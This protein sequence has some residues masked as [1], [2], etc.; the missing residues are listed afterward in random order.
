MGLQSLNTIKN[1]FK[2][3]FI[4]T[5]AQ[6]WDMFDSFR[7]KS[8][9][10]AATDVDGLDTLLAAKASNA[11]FQAHTTAENAH[12]GLFG[13]LRTWVESQIEGVVVDS[14]NLGA[15]TPLSTIPDTINVHGFAV[16]EG[17][18]ANCGG[19]V[20]PATS[21]AFISR[22]AGVWKITVTELDLG[23]YEK[24]ID[25]NKKLSRKA[26]TIVGKNKY[27]KNT[28]YLNHFMGE[29]GTIYAGDGFSISDFIEVNPLT[30]Y[31]PS[32]MLRF[33][34]YF[35][36]NKNVIVGGGSFVNSFTTSVDTKYV[37]V[38]LSL[39]AQILTM[40]LEEGN[41]VTAYENYKYI[42]KNE[43]NIPIVLEKETVAP[44]QTKGILIPSKNL[45]NPETSTFNSFISWLDGNIQGGYPDG[46]AS[47]FI[48]VIPGNIYSCNSNQ[49]FK[50]FYAAN[51]VFVSGSQFGTFPV[52]IPAGCYYIKITVGSGQLNT[53]QFE[54]GST[55]TEYHVPGWTSKY[56]YYGTYTPP[57][58][59]KLVTIGDSITE[60][61]AWQPKVATKLELIHTNLG[62]S[63]T[64]LSGFADG[65][66][67][68]QGMWTTQRI[69][70][71][72]VDTDVI[73]LN[74]GINDYARSYV[75]GSIDSTNT[76]EFYG[77]LNKW[78]ERAMERAPSAKIFIA[79]TTYG[80]YGAFSSNPNY[81]DNNGK[82][83]KDFADAMRNIAN[84]YG[85][86]VIDF[87]RECMVNKWNRPA[88]APDNLHPNADYADRMANVAIKAMTNL[89]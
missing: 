19:V 53:C 72:P 77:A 39:E 68:G 49:T 14:E 64:S 9:K 56:P 50:A 85:F 33:T 40:Q 11:V 52:T 87:S 47:D 67:P 86:P 12:A 66:A 54:E 84:K 18:Y 42:I 1:W 21:Y 8:D 23:G 24:T 29:D 44:E 79:T 27:N 46:V 22:V 3:N 25:T 35:D 38:T 61:N 71:I 62:M 16:E 73:I 17:T 37:K 51:K 28:V 81:Q 10:V 2:T 43:E 5:Q 48:S 74:G 70:Q 88:M 32:G 34:T 75:I 41:A 65:G 4:P 55:Q 83:S 31:T 45:F 6:F 80:E 15:L 78:V 69:A 20:V 58:L 36:I 76:D 82:T 7:H 60:M 26:S 59:K 89:I 57:V 13:A 63:G 30:T